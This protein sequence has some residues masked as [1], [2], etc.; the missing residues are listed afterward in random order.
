[1]FPY[2]VATNI[3]RGFNDRGGYTDANTKDHIINAMVHEF[4]DVKTLMERS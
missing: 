2:L 3:Q 4:E 1:M